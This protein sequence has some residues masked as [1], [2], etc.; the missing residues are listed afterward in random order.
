MG[1]HDFK[2][3]HFQTLG[4][5]C[6]ATLRVVPE[7][8]ANDKT[9][10]PAVLAETP[11]PSSFCL[12]HSHSKPLWWCQCDVS[13]LQNWSQGWWVT[14]C[15]LGSKSPR[16]PSALGHMPPALG[17]IDPDEDVQNHWR[18]FDWLLPQLRFSDNHWHVDTNSKGFKFFLIVFKLIFFH[19][20]RLLLEMIYILQS[21]MGN[22]Q[23]AIE[24]GCINP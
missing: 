23:F 9:A 21:Y 12:P 17:A 13:G 14:Y 3:I 20:S 22:S 18:L 6:R 8:P 24:W 4:R 1:A 10:G 11:A 19:L 2:R 5:T 7:E 15:W 16:W